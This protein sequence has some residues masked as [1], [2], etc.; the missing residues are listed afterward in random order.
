MESSL[1][2]MIVSLLSIT[3]ASA[4]VVGVVFQT[5]KGPAEQNRLARTNSA[6]VKALP[7]YDNDP[8]SEKILTKIDGGEVTV[9]PAKK[10]NQA[11]GYAVETFTNEGFGGK[12]KLMVGFKAN[13]EITS[14]EVLEHKETPGLGDKIKNDKSNFN[15]QFIGKNPSTMKL[16]VKKDGGTI[17][18]ITASTISSRAYID[19]VQRASKVL[20][21]TKK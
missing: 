10:N 6:W 8:G 2:N 19:A 5:T 11:V 9:Y 14:I 7:E 20:E 15:V 12:F 1:K 3:L 4:L 16:A 21:S 18:A 17:D 13:G